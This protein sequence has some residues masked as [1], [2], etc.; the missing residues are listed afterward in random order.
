MSRKWVFAAIVSS[1]ALAT[2]LPAQA[3]D[4]PLK[5]PPAPLPPSWTGFYVGAQIG[6]GWNDRNVTYAANDPTAAEAVNGTNGLPGEQPF[7]AHGLNLSGVTGGVEAGYNWQVNSASLV[8]LEADFSASGIHG[9]GSG[10]SV[11]FAVPGVTGTQTVASEQKVDWWGTMRARV[12]WLA[13]KDLLLYGTGGFAYGRVAVSDSYILNGPPGFRVAGGLAGFSFLCSVG[14]TCFTGAT[15]DT[16]YG[17]TAGAGGEWRWARNW[18]FKAEYLYVNLGKAS[19]N[20]VANTI[21]VPGAT[22]ASYRANF[23]D[24]GFHVVRVGANYHF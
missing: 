10:T 2:G 15:S 1:I 7:A 19:V 18:S 8:G 9:S 24:V 13:S 21:F 23:G 22:P 6:G 12:G 20:A 5:A 17:W 4:L 11:L 16:K 3:A 14:V